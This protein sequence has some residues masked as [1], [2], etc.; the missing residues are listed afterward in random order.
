MLFICYSIKR[1]NEV[2][3]LLKVL[4][5]EV[6]FL[7]QLGYKTVEIKFQLFGFIL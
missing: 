7:F 5:I 1:S 6:H 3:R 4:K 2:K